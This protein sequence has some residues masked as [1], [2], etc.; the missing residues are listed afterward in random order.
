MP[1]RVEYASPGLAGL[2]GLLGGQGRQAVTDR[3]EAAKARLLAQQIA[4][5]QKGIAMRAQAQAAISANAQRAAGKRQAAALSAQRSSTQQQIKGRAQREMQASEQA[6]KRMAVQAGLQEELAEQAYDRQIQMKEEEARQRANQRKM[7]FGEGAKRE[8]A[9]ANTALDWLNGPGKNLLDP[10]SWQSAV[11]QA[12]ARA[13]GV[14]GSFV[15]DASKKYSDGQGIDEEW[16]NNSGDLVSRDANGKIYTI[17][18]Y[19]YSQEYLQQERQQDQREKQA[20]EKADI[21]KKKQAFVASNVGKEYQKQIPRRVTPGAYFGT[22]IEEQHSELQVHTLGSATDLAD[23]IFGGGQQQAPQPQEA[24]P[25]QQAP[26]QTG[27]PWYFQ[28]GWQNHPSAKILSIEDEDLRLPPEIGYSRAV[29]RTWQE[30]YGRDREKWPVEVRKIAAELD[31][32]RRRSAKKGR[33][34]R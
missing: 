34:A 27:V 28:P 32:I 4:G 29:L 11:T 14:Q 15:P 26:Q 5:Q 6:F 24:P 2:A 22:N 17:T 8:I 31:E 23:K 20:A 16:V 19:R 13:A 9:N 18:P 30:K 21:L 10:Q 3:A 25:Q 33:G 12:K 7:I 1:I